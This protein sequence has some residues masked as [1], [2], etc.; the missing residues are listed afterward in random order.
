[1]K[2]DKELPNKNNDLKF[3]N[4]FHILLDT[5]VIFKPKMEREERISK[6]QIR[7]HGN[8][9]FL[10]NTTCTKYKCYLTVKFVNQKKLSAAFEWK[11]QQ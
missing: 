10:K 3:E 6:N 4:I 5:V 8:Q 9:K 7:N 11:L 1:M 2:L